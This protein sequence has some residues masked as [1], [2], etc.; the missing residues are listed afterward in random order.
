MHAHVGITGE[1]D[2]GLESLTVHGVYTRLLVAAPVSPALYDTDQGT[3]D[4][5]Y[6]I[7]PAESIFIRDCRIYQDPTCRVRYRVDDPFN[8]A[9]DNSWNRFA[10]VALRGSRFEV[11]DSEVKGGG[12]H[13]CFLDARYFRMANNKLCVGHWGNAL[14]ANFHGER[15]SEKFT[16]EDN[17]IETQTD[18]IGNGHSLFEAIQDCYVA[19]NTIKDYFYT[20]DN[21]AILYH[22]FSRRIVAR[23]VSATSGIMHWGSG[24]DSVVDGN[25][26]Y[27]T[28]G[29]YIWSL[30]DNNGAYANFGGNYFMQVIHNTVN[31]GA[32]TAPGGIHV[33]PGGGSGGID[34][35]D[36]ILRGNL[37]QNDG[38]IQTPRCG[39][40]HVC[41]GLVIEDN[42][43]VDSPKGLV[44]GDEASTVVRRNRT[45]DGDESETDS[46]T[47][48]GHF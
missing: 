9:K 45:D 10:A 14:K 39:D 25:R 11:V 21:E 35:L 16:M 41:E 33:I 40:R 1:G 17:I 5:E 3:Q 31:G 6:D 8:K 48:R 29:I 26:L 27:S 12:M 32:W 22:S 36:V 2:F 23:T 46:A 37:L 20:G 30:S 24:F 34:L 13:V 4:F 47:P 42:A 7:P 18:E 28:G 15:M 19:R 38:F 43:F 44:A